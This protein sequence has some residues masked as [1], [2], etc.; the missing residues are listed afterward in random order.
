[1]PRANVGAARRVPILSDV[2]DSYAPPRT[3]LSAIHPDSN[4][5]FAPLRKLSK[6]VRRNAFCF[7]FGL[8]RVALF[9]RASYLL[10][11][12]GLKSDPVMRP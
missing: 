10:F 4:M 9:R 12:T 1:M 3:A 7:A 5:Q 6:G 11:R 8:L 2:G